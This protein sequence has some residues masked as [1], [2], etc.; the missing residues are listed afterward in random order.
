MFTR[1]HP[2]RTLQKAAS[3]AIAHAQPWPDRLA[4]AGYIAKGAL[5]LLVGGLAGAAAVG[6][7]GEAT[8]PSGALVTVARAP[9]GR[10]VLVAVALGLLAHAGF[11]G[12]LALVG[13]PYDHRG[14]VQGAMRRLVN[15][16]SAL[17]YLGL[18]ITASALA[19]GRSARVQP[20]GN[21]EARDWSARLLSLPFG[22]SLLI[23]VATAILV[24]AVVQ[25]VRAFTPGAVRRRLRLEEM[26]AREQQTVSIVG[27]V[28]FVAR[29]TVLAVIGYYLTE[30][31]VH[32]TPRAA[33]GAGGAL[34]AVW[35]QPHGGLLLGLVA[36]GLMAFGAYGLLEARWRRLFQR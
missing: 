4:R 34:R 13:E 19:L 33:R 27:R 36:A 3:R 20:D 32:R 5:F 24:A 18:A 6:L 7:G 26:S 1:H 29:A 2:L 35:A 28:A 31:A 8:D 25:L 30:V 23:G 10:F 16:V 9:A 15:A 12:A 21:A 14:P 22:Q 17:F 11:R